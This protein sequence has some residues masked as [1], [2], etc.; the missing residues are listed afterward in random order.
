MCHL[1]TCNNT[2]TWQ[3]IDVNSQYHTSSKNLSRKFLQWSNTQTSAQ[4]NHACRSIEMQRKIEETASMNRGIWLVNSL[5]GASQN[6]VRNQLLHKDLGAISTFRVC[7]ASGST[8]FIGNPQNLEPSEQTL[9]SNLGACIR[10]H[11]SNL[12]GRK[13]TQRPATP[14]QGN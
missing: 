14:G 11:L 4:S 12:H 8:S 7:R 6:L 1:P 13:S 10:V 5:E 9:G 3:L 2:N